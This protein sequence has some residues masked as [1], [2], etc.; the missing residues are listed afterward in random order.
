MTKLKELFGIEKVLI[1]GGGY[2][3]WTFAD[4]GMIDELS[5]VLAPADDGEQKVTLFERTDSSVNKY[6]AFTLTS[7]KLLDGN[8]VW[9]RYKFNNAKV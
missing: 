8:G 2:T 3:D 6:I 4:S 1:A 5:L 9:L 7:V